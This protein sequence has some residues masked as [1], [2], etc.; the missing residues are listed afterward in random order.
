MNKL[1]FVTILWAF[2]FSLIG[3]FLSG[4][5]DSYFSVFT[6]VALACIVFLPFT[7]FRGVDRR[8]ALGIMGIGAVQ[9]GAMYLFYYN[10][11]LYLS[12]PEVALFTIFTPFYVTLVYDAFS[13]KFRKLYL[14]SV[15]TA[16]LGAFIIKYGSIN[17]GALKGFLLVQGANICF[18]FGQSAYKILIEKFKG[19]EQKSVFGYFHFGAFFVTLIAFL[20]FGNFSKTSLDNTQ[21]FVLIW[22]GVVA[23]GLGYFLWNKGA[24]EVDSGVLAIMNNALIPAAILVNL[25]FWYK[26]TDLARLAIGAAILYLSLILHKKIMKFYKMV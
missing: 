13:L 2:S 11:F 14:I 9:I 26:D 4:R 1:V 21:I 20:L 15:G 7:S 6:R 3:E 17:D 8:L 18:G 23:S 19:V 5:V 10:S 12:V 24:C 22:L 25:I 16:V